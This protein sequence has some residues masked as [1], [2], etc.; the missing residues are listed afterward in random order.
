MCSEFALPHD[1]A[2]QERQ[3]AYTIEESVLYKFEDEIMAP[4]YDPEDPMDFGEL[5]EQLPKAFVKAR[6]G[7]RCRTEAGLEEAHQLG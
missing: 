5:K 6:L 3:V 2:Q 7:N 4:A 1:E